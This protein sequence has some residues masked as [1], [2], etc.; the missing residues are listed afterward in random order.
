MKKGNKSS[1]E[2]KLFFALRSSFRT[3]EKKEWPRN[4]SETTAR[5]DFKTRVFLERPGTCSG[6]VSLPVSKNRFRCAYSRRPIE[7]ALL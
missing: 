1:K 6:K 7:F 2:L 3:E 4:T 5:V